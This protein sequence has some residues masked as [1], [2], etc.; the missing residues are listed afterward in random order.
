MDVMID[1]AKLQDMKGNLNA[2]VT[3]SNASLYEGPLQP[4]QS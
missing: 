1:S 3:V 4:L 2:F